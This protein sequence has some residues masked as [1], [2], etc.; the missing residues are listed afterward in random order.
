MK[1]E[2]QKEHQQLVGEWTYESA[3]Y[4]HR[5]T[6]NSESQVGPLALEQTRPCR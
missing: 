6:G 5:L 4:G 1:T 3:V 2:S